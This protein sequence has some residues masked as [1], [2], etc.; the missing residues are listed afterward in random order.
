MKRIIV[1]STLAATMAVML[2]LAGSASAV[3]PTVEKFGPFSGSEQIADCGSGRERFEVW[4]DYMFEVQV[5]TYYDSAGNPDYA[6]EYYTFEDFFYNTDT[7]EGFSEHDR[8]NAVVDLSSGQEVTSSAVAYRVTVPGEGVVLLQ[9]GTI[10][11]DEDGNATFIAGP[12][13]VFPESD[14]QKLCEALAPDQDT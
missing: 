5:I 14:T 9:A 6:R 8:S 1:L 10:R 13:Q 12:H 2:A 7:G 11:F 4:T 3:G